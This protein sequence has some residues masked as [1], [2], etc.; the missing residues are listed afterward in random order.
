MVTLSRSAEE[1]LFYWSHL[2]TVFACTCKSLTNP[3]HTFLK[4]LMILADQV[5]AAVHAFFW[6][7]T[8][9]DVFSAKIEFLV[10]PPI[11]QVLALFCGALT[12]VIEYPPQ[13]VASLVSRDSIYWRLLLTFLN[14]SLSALLYQGTDAALYH[15]IAL[16]IFVYTRRYRQSE[17]SNKV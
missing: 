15:V 13:K 9:W 16:G 5:L 2:V 4:L 8:Y 12:L 11:L 1:A 14:A 3:I 17:A 10:T 7:K 6:P